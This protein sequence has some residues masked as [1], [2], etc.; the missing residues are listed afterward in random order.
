MIGSLDSNLVRAYCELRMK[1]KECKKRV[2]PDLYLQAFWIGKELL[3]R[4]SEIK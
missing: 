2:Y 3:C 4:M 1:K